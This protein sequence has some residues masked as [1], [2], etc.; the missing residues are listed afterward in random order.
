MSKSLNAEI[1]ILKNELKNFEKFGSRYSDND[2]YLACKTKLDKIYDKKVKG[3]RIRS[4][5]DWYKKG[6]KSAKFFLIFEKRHSIQNQ[7]K[8]LVVNYE[9]VK[10][11]SEI[12]K[13]YIL[14]IRS[15]FLKIT[16]F[17]DKR[18]CN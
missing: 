17:L 7:I 14:F 8:P 4:K 18:Y 12:N 16:P 5:C 9:L 1:E 6:E 13:T 15:F 11:Q 2:E 3:L 10:E